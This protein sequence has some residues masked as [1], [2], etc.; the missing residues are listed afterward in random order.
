AAPVFMAGKYPRETPV[1]TAPA[2]RYVAHAGRTR[3]LAVLAPGF[4]EYELDT[5]G[6][7]LITILRAVGQLSRPD[8]PTRPGHAGWPVATPL[9][10]CQGHERL[11]L[12]LVPFS[13]S[14][15][16]HES[17][18]AELW[19]DAF[20]PIQPVWLRQASPLTLASLDVHLEGNGLLFS[21]VKPAEHGGD[22]VLRCYNATAEPAAGVWHISKPVSGA[23]RA[24][25]DEHVLHEIRLS[26][27]SRSIPFHAAPREIVTIMVSLSGPD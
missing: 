11:Q 26:E 5:G 21:G 1:S 24:R 13:G 27:G 6:D 19:E 15:S 8:L 18:L 12:A 22:I 2:H 4:F 17:A 20:L 16:E 23:R 9:A 25:A 3:G 10:Q 7:L 14:R